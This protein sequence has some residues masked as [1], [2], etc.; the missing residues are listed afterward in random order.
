MKKLVVICVVL[1]VVL[2]AII[3]VRT[4]RFVPPPRPPSTAASI[5]VDDAA[6]AQHLAEAVRFQTI[7]TQDK[8]QFDGNA[9]HAFQ[10]FLEKTF[11]AFHAA[12]KCERVGEFSLLYTWPGSDATLKPL[13]MMAH[14]D[15]V[16]ADGNTLKEWKHPPFEGTIADGYVWGRG[17]LDDKGSLMAIFEAVELLLRDGFQPVRTI[18]FSFGHDEELGNQNG[19]TQAA[20]LLKSR[21]VTLE[22]VLDEGGSILDGLVPGVS[23]PIAAIGIAEKG[24]LSLELAVEAAGGHSSTPPRHT[25]LGTLA[26]AITR[27]ENNPAPADMAYVEPFLLNI[28]PYTPLPQRAIMANLWAFRPLVQRMLSS[29]PEMNASIR[30]TA[31]PTM[32]NA[33]VKENVLPSRA[34]AVVNYRLLPGDTVESVRACARAL[35]NDDSVQLTLL[36]QPH[37]ASP[38]SDVHSAAYRRIEQSLREVRGDADIV[39]APCLTLGGTDAR[40]F[41]SLTPNV[42]RF[43]PVPLDKAALHTVHGVN[44]CIRIQHYADLIRFYAQYIRNSRE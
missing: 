38:V 23:A 17:T 27:I 3:G 37:E 30:T 15:V 34:T 26:K 41:C 43:V 10:A 7:S 14:Q 40:N 35:I 16:P 4:A 36:G 1:A 44:E 42:F 6:A 33:G 32:A 12:L 25:A 28:G 20:E 24:Y 2:G 5:P 18:Y 19:A 22:S 21:G 13:L 29:V 31:A 11:P 8:A 9:F 39:V